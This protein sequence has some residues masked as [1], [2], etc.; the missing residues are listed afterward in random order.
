MTDPLSSKPF[1]GDVPSGEGLLHS[2]QEITEAD[3]LI[4]AAL[5]ARPA[6]QPDLA[7]ENQA[8]RT[9]AQ[10]L[11]DDPQSM[12]KTL[13]EI[14]RDL[15]RADTAGISLLETLADGTTAFRWIAIAGALEFLEQ[16]TTPGNFSPCG[17]TI[18]CGQPQLYAHPERYY[19]YL[20]HPQFPIVEGLLL[21]LYVNNQQLGTLWLVSHHK[22]RQFDRE[23]QRLMTSLSGFTAAALQRMHQR[24]KDQDALQREQELQT[25][26]KRAETSLRQS[27]EFN[28]QVLD[29]SDDCIKVLD[30]SGRL[31]YMNPR[32]QALIGIQDPT[33]LLNCS[34]VEFWQGADR[35]AALN[36]LDTAKAGGVGRFQGYSPTLA[37]EP[38]CWD[39]KLTAIRGAEGQ[40]E[41]L[42]CISRDITEQKRVEDERKRAELNAEFLADVSQGLIGASSVSEV[43]QTVGEHLNRYLNAS[44]CAFVA[45]NERAKEAVVDCDWHQEDVP[46][47]VGV[48]SLPEFVCDQFLQAIK[49]G[50][51]V[52]VRDV[53]APSSIVD[54]QKFAT[55]KI[56]AF[57]N[58]PLSR[59]N[60]WQFSFGVYHQSPYNWRTDEIE[61]MRELA[62]RFWMKLERAR[63][64][65]ALRESEARFRSFAENSND[66]IWITAAD[67]YRLIYVSPSFEQVWGR[68]AS[69]IYTDLS[70]F[71]E[72]IHPDDR[73]RIQ[74]GWQQCI[75]GGFS[76]EYRVIRPDG[77]I[78]WIHDRGFPVY[79]DQGE[80]LYL[81]GIA[82]TI[83]ERKQ[84][85]QERERFLAVG[86]DL[87]VITGLDGYFQWISP[88]FERILGWTMGE[89]VAHPWAEF[90]HPD[91]INTSISEIDSLFS[92]NQT[93]AFENRYRH[94]D[95]SYRWLLWNAQPYPEEQVVY[96]A[97]VD[98]TARKQAEE[99]LRVSEER[100]QRAIAIETVGVIFFRTEG[101]I[102]DAND[103]FLRMSGY[104][105][106]DFE[107]GRVRW[108]KLTPPEWMPA[109]HRAVQEFLTLGRTTPYEK[110]YIRKDGSRWWGL[111]AA[112]R[113]NGTEGVEFIIDIS[114]RKRVEAEREQLLAKER[115][116]ANQLQGLTTAALA[117]NSALSVEE[118][119]QVII[120][121]AA[122]I[123]GAH[124]SVIS[125]TIDQNWAQAIN[126]V[127]LSDKYAAWRDYDEKTDG[128]G[129]YACV[130][131]LN[132]PMRMTQ[133]ELEAH[134]SWQ[135]FG[136]AAD[137]HPPMRGWLAAPLV[138]RDGRNIGLIQLSDKYGGE[139][140]ASDE[141]ILVQLAQ[142]ASVAVENTRLYAAEQQAR[143]AAE[144]S[145]EEAETAN[146]L[147]D[148]FLAVLSHELRSPL[149]P[150]L[151]WSRLLQTRKLDAA[152]TAIALATIE[153]NA[154]L[155]S[156][157]IEDLLDVSRILQGKLS[158]NVTPIN[159][160]ATIRAALETVRLAAEAKA[161]E[162]EVSLD[163]NVS[164]VSGD[165]TRLQQVVW[166]LVSNAVK[167]TPS[168]GRVEVRLV[169]AERQAQITVRDNGKGIPAEF[170]PYVFDYFRQADSATT[171]KFGG[172][173]LGLAIVR[174][175]VELHGGTVEADSPGEGLGATFTVKL[176][177][178]SKQPSVNEQDELSEPALDLQGVQVLVVDDDT[179]TRDLTALVLEQAGA[180]VSTAASA[181][182]ALQALAQA[183][184]D[185]LLSD[186]GMPEMDGYMLLQRVRALEA[187]QKIPAIALTAYAGEFNQQQA[188][189][190]GF[191]Q[192]ISKPV[193][194]EALVNAIAAL[195]KH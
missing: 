37:G 158:L 48:Y 100:L 83:T 46:S 40:V 28:R 143:S 146:R 39:V 106:E 5:A 179:D 111:F 141:S 52:V 107:Q 112:S 120:E 108:D 75:Q 117:V 185:I 38:K 86:A 57:I 22:Q 77:S 65:A 116:Y 171:R 6:R 168:G 17:T 79:D 183:K 66:V 13:V 113:L 71:V 181:V 27:E 72:S 98:I 160:A 24:Q 30:F 118:V 103:A 134:P 145:R 8:L 32:G 90:V 41:Q 186:I 19:T 50:Q 101:V 155:Q 51:T 122:S 170:L 157:L 109:S 18:R 3:V 61:L 194:P 178:M 20:H 121:Q 70:R 31:L 140:T 169:Q 2:P 23:D 26:Q 81:A 151:G 1:Q 16:T 119:L 36:A 138:E 34:W 159:L 78:V 182:E 43:I 193:E 162:V 93:F 88:T 187:G 84:F 161:I 59:D 177:L 114:E 136:N 154:K 4:T 190:A 132:R 54:E 135:G 172:L 89:L 14:A 63:A 148:E 76:Q 21:P 95:G 115:H 56:G 188:L 69:E 129:I 128:S 131:H 85:E 167:F 184:P 124:Q 110:E 97:A 189:Q 42:L 35:Q 130:C 195:I 73:E 174:H 96:G 58:V 64:E 150:I 175:L 173:G 45:I 164:S 68:S 192:H 33:S 91:D 10:H 49:V 191:Q 80:L 180:N 176:P 44:I 74:A 53:A 94:K 153:R 99:A 125:L 105:R 142:M 102:G 15:C 62:N 67:E 123:I 60:E 9:L 7:A 127:H 12:L 47:L 165:A 87:R 137:K 149:N 133:A 139:F 126:A 166:N 156:E 25:K 163:A 55:L 152:K 82:E 29:S 11:M 104:N 92:G 147:K 144:A